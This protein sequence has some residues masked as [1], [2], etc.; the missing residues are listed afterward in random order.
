MNIARIICLHYWTVYGAALAAIFGMTEICTGTICVCVPTLRPLLGMSKR[1]RNPLHAKERSTPDGAAR[2][3]ELS[4]RRGPT[5]H[6]QVS[7]VWTESD[8]DVERGSVTN[9]DC[10]TIISPPQKSYAARGSVST[11][12]TD[13]STRSLRPADSPVFKWEPEP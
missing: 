13:G 11:L 10:R 7:M 4:E 6:S 8:A 9:E 2:H 5:S 3:H 12:H 1:Q